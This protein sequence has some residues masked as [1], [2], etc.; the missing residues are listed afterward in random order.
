MPEIIGSRATRWISERLVF[1]PKDERFCK[2]I[3]SVRCDKKESPRDHG[4]GW[5]DVKIRHLALLSNIFVGCYFLR[6]VEC[7]YIAIL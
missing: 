3:M 4:L 5:V 2:Q 7:L 6:L 1:Q